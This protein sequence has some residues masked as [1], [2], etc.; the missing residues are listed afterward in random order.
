MAGKATMDAPPVA[1]AAEV[2]T[3]TKL[4]AFNGVVAAVKTLDKAEQY[5]VLHAAAKYFG[6]SIQLNG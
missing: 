4:E 1:A 5:A 3:D 6:V 2:A